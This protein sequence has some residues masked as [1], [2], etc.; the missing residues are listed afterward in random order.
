MEQ[1]LT[2][3]TLGVSDLKRSRAFY[4]EKFGWTPVENSSE[5]IVF[6]AL[7]GGIQLALFPDQELARDA[8]VDGN[9]SGF[10]KFSLAYNVRS[11]KEVDEVMA[12]LEQKGVTILKRPEKVFWGGYSGY[13]ADPDNN[14][15][16]VAYN[17][18]LLPD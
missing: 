5:E 2:L 15:W 8:Q 14:L 1:R 17:P 6:F 12:A 10:R 3:I 11:E 4:V 9:G 13:I 18:Y 7:K 16:E